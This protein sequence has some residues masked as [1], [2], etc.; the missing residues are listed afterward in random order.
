MTF[1]GDSLAL[2]LQGPILVTGHTGFK[3][4]WLTLLLESL[5]VEVVGISLP[6]TIDSLYSKLNRFGA[7]KEY[8]IDITDSKELSKCI[9][10]TKP[11]I[12]VHLAAQA[13][14]LE[15]YKDPASTFKTNILGTV[16]V[17]N[18]SFGSSDISIVL[19][20]TTDKV[21]RN[22]NSGNRFI[23]S[24]PLEGKDPYSSSKVGAESAISAWQHIRELSGGPRI[25]AARSGN[26]IGGGDFSQNRLLPD[27]VRAALNNSE[28][29]IRNPLSTR[30]WQHV[31][32][33]L[34]GYIKAIS[35]LKTS[36]SIKAIN[37]GPNGKSLS[38]FQVLEIA[39]K[40]NFMSKLRVTFG[41][42]ASNIFEAKALELNATL[43]NSVLE[44][45]PA[46]SQAAAVEATISWWED[47]SSEKLS[48]SE[49][50]QKDIDFLFAHLAKPK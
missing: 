47:V 22:D 32:D 9:F 39:Q 37:F 18:E 26:V 35:S 46:W 36:D 49:A 12:I 28:L 30:P 8:F 4:T 29:I 20:A 50:C 21:Y 44:W 34:F 31:L 19:V 38:V 10:E 6:P 16:N 11:K 41:N 42:E 13:L 23:E 7:M 33:P 48:P 45:S 2:D 15:S 5:G 24:D 14:V 25:I 17:L 40:S 3:G 1:N 27:M 43:A